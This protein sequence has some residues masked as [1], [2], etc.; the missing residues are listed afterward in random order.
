MSAYQPVHLFEEFFSS[1]ITPQK[2]LM[3]LAQSKQ[4]EKVFIENK[5]HI[6]QFSNNIWFMEI[7]EMLH[8][9]AKNSYC[10]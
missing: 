2:T 6:Y 5:Q 10:I 9:F 8:I 1:H 7:K 3:A 4:R